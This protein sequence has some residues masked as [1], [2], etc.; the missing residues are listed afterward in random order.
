DE[1]LKAGAQLIGGALASQRLIAELENSNRLLSALGDMTAAMLQPGASR[2]QVIDAVV[3]HLTDSEVPEFDFNFAT[4]YL[5]DQGDQNEA[6]VVRMAAGAATAEAIDSAEG[7]RTTGA[8][9][10]QTRRSEEHTSEL[11]SR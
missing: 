10:P 4:V 9:G 8:R 3:G 1:M 5:L 7:S 2:H 11:Q 6:T